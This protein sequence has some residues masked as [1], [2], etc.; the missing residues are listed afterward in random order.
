MRFPS[1]R[2]RHRIYSS[3]AVQLVAE[4]VDS[5]SDMEEMPKEECELVVR[6]TF[7]DLRFVKVGGKECLS[8]PARTGG[9]ET[10]GS[11]L[12]PHQ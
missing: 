2:S 12:A 1:V 11:S 8:A 4:F 5:D 6:R 7:F 3:D 9:D 10:I